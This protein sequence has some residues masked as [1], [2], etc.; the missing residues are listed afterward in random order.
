MN[1]RVKASIT[2]AALT[3]AVL[4]T[5][6]YLNIRQEEKEAGEELLSGG[7]RFSALTAAQLVSQHDRYYEQ[8]FTTFLFHLREIYSLNQELSRIEIVDVEGNVHLGLEEI[9]TALPIPA[10]RKISPAQWEHETLAWVTPQYRYLSMG[11]ERLL[12]ISYP[13]LLQSGVHR[14]NVIYYYSFETLE[15]RL[16]DI[17]TSAS[18]L[19]LIFV[20]I[21]LLG[22]FLFSYG[23]TRNLKGLVDHAYLIAG[24]NLDEPVHIR[25]KD[26]LGELA[27]SFEHM[28]NELKKKNGEIESYNRELETK[29]QERTE[30]LE[31][32][33]VQLKGNNL[34]LQRVNEK[35]LELDRLKSEFL[36]NTSHELRTPLTS[37]I[38]YS[39]CMLAELDGPISDKQKE[40]VKKIISSGKDL[41]ALINRILDFSKIESGRMK[42]DAEEVHLKEIVEEAV[43]TVRPLS[44]D[45]GLSLIA[46]I[47]SDLP[48]LVGDR[49][50]IKQAILNLLSNAVKFT[51]EGFI[52]IRV[53]RNNG[54]VQVSVQDTGIGIGKDNHDTIFDAFRQVD[55]SAKRK[56]G[57][58]G[59][60]LTISK[61]LIELHR[62][63][64]WVESEEGRGTTF[65]FTLPL[66]PK[67]NGN[68]T[69]NT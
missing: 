50:R 12:E 61:M 25:S 22:S 63:K 6:T 30:E 3:A 14:Y 32:L 36:A 19:F 65:S 10:G 55:G 53:F 62:G 21:G 8:A 42:L 26:E 47:E 64:I 7:M 20:G 16:G 29:V 1:L 43:T 45:K 35:L 59:L 41:L 18:R 67:E 33:T 46:N 58:S 38:G 28:R 40:N 11:E 2:S 31:A 13:V 68:G 49:M 27:S 60:G 44:E 15:K 17:K 23:L 4:L 66:S 48:S 69:E 39:Q 52:W 56:F 37:I 5:H 24:G 9:E 51:D 57:G 34:E 54:N